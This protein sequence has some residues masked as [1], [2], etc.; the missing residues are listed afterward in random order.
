MTTTKALGLWNLGTSSFGRNLT[1]QKAKELIKAAWKMGYSSFDTAFSYNSADSML[2]SAMRSMGVE[3]ERY[4]IWSKVMPVPTLKKKAEAS[5]RRLGSDYFDILMLHWPTEGE[6]LFAS[7]KALEELKKEGKTREIGVS[8]FPISLLSSVSRD[9]GVSYH[10]RPLSLIWN[11]DWEEEKKNSIKTIAYAPGGFGLLGGKYSPL[12][13]PPDKRATIEAL[14][15]PHFP[16]L[17]EKM[18]S[19]SSRYGISKYEVALSWTEAQSPWAIVR[20]AG[21]KE[22]LDAK[23]MEMEKKDVDALSALSDAVTLSY[24][25]DNIFSHNWRLS[26]IQERQ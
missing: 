10:E 9:F 5:L 23:T 24:S 2:Y 25:S 14:W 3:R 6:S 17:L 22:D 4:Q 20:G 19:L 15:S 18:D 13:P 7:L 8:N 12:D 1:P 11:K 26:E 16:S 21:H